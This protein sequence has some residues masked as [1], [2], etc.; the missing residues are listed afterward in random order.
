MLYNI[1][2]IISEY[3]DIPNIKIIFISSF[4]ISAEQIMCPTTNYM[5]DNYIIQNVENSEYLSASH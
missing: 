1:I 2:V 4:A 5:N 3:L